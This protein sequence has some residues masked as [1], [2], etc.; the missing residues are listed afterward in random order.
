MIKKESPHHAFI[1]QWVAAFEAFHNRKYFFTGRDAKVVPEFIE[2]NFPIEEVIRLA[3]LGWKSTDPFIKSR[4]S[5]LFSF[6]EVIN[7]LSIE[8]A[9]P[10]YNNHNI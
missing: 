5:D 1:A 4:S 6:S 9:K 2:N 8:D 3:K 10:A 7:R